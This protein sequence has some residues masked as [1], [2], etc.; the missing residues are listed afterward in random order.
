MIWVAPSSGG[1]AIRGG[2][3][4]VEGGGEARRRL[5]QRGDQG[6]QVVGPDVQVGIGDDQDVVPGGGQHVDEVADFQVGTVPGGVDDECDIAAGKVG[7]EPTNDCGGGIG[8]GLHA[9]D[10]LIGRVVESADTGQGGFEQ[11]FVTVQRF[12]DGDRTQ[13]SR[14]GTPPEGEPDGE[15]PA[16]KGLDD[17][18]QGQEGRDR[19]EEVNERGH[20]VPSRKHP[21]AR[22]AGAEQGQARE[23]PQLGSIQS[24]RAGRSDARWR[25]EQSMKQWRYLRTMGGCQLSCM[26]GQAR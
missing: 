5:L 11:R 16:G 15:D 1:Q 8:G 23:M 12:E 13:G 10:D 7:L 17:A 3:P 20:G 2:Q 21:Q 9:E 24:W 18:D 22:H 6:V 19:G 25:H 14:G 4:G 26:Q